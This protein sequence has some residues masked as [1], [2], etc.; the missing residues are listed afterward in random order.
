M[1]SRCRVDG[2]LYLDVC[3]VRREVHL[4]HKAGDVPAGVDAVQLRSERQVVEVHRALSGAH[5]Q[6]TRIRTE[7]VRKMRSVLKVFPKKNV[8]EIAFNE[9]FES[10]YSPFELD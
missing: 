8:C 5:G 3:A 6:V 2:A 7:P 1:A 4:H 9:M 10:P